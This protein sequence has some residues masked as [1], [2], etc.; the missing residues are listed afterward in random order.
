MNYT[1]R[2]SL[3]RSEGTLAFS[4]Q[5]ENTFDEPEKSKMKSDSRFSDENRYRGYNI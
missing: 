2:E 4:L 3:R 1:S 5:S